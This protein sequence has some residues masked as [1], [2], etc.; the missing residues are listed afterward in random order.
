MTKAKGIIKRVQ[1]AVGRRRHVTKATTT[2]GS[3]KNKKL[4]SYLIQFLKSKKI[5]LF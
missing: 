2:T 4:E 5:A 3:Q 1:K